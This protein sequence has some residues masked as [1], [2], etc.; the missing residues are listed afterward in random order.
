MIRPSLDSFEKSKTDKECFQKWRRASG[1][2]VS[3]TPKVGQLNYSR[4]G[5]FVPRGCDAIAAFCQ[6]AI[7]AMADRRALS[8]LTAA[9]KGAGARLRGVL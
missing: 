7:M 6:N 8:G 4:V 3:S 1:E 5:T 2:L 9:S